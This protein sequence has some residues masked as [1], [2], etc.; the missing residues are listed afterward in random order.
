M[1]NVN[2]ILFKEEVINLLIKGFSGMAIGVV[3]IWAKYHL[4][5]LS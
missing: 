3:G 2:K 5:E 1:N 4:S